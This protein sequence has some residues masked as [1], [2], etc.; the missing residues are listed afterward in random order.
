MRYL[1]WLAS[2]IYTFPVFLYIEETSKV[3][4]KKII[5]SQP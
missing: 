3:F 5:F 1:R 2:L 4:N